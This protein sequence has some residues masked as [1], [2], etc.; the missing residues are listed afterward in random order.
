MS[1]WVSDVSGLPKSASVRVRVLEFFSGSVRVGY[2]IFVSDSV[3]FG[4]QLSGFGFEFGGQKCHFY[5]KNLQFF[6]NI[7]GIENFFVIFTL[8]MEYFR[9]QN[10]TQHKYIYDC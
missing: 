4:Y 6:S 2:W 3:R 10:H 8:K 1:A 5:G 9:T 7:K